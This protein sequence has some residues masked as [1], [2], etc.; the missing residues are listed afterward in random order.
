M[1]LC[2]GHV[3]PGPDPLVWFCILA[4]GPAFVGLMVLIARVHFWREYQH[5][6]QGE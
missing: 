5:R 2:P 4:A 6:K 3:D 1:I